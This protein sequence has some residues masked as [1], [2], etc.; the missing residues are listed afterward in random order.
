[1]SNTLPVGTAANDVQ[2]A[3]Q[4]QLDDIDD[5]VERLVDAICERLELDVWRVATTVDIA[6]APFT[7]DMFIGWHTT[8]RQGQATKVCGTLSIAPASAT[9]LFHVGNTIVA[10]GYAHKAGDAADEFCGTVGAHLDRTVP[11]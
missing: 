2:W 4:T 1:M 8:A 3:L 7:V 5:A 6:L 9:A 10:R 11:T